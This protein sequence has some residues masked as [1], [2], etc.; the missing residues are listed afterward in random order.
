[1]RSKMPVIILA[2]SAIYV[3]LLGHQGDLDLYIHPRYILFTRAF[4]LIC[5][6][7]LV[8]NTAMSRTEAT[9]KMG[10]STLPIL[11]V[12]LFAVLLPAK[13][14]TSA[15][16]SQRVVADQSAASSLFQNSSA[17]IFSNSTKIL[18][19]ADWAQIIASNPGTEY[20]TNKTV[21]V[22]GFIVDAGLGNDVVWV[23]RFAITCCAVDAQPV[24]IPVKIVNWR[25][26]H[27]QD[28]WVDVKGNFKEMET[29]KGR[30][31]VL[32]PDSVKKISEPDNPYAY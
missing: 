17:N 5:L 6:A 25:S 9:H 20:F 22:S 19:V 18:S 7:V 23:A 24:G 11:M 3:L 2:I 8:V 15:T 14:L 31:I 26:G 13:S 10:L 1:M 29:N 16:V 28:Q 4:A 21:H 30:Q 32:I 12:L 27:S